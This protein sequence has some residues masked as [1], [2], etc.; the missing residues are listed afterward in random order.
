MI[1]WV[2]VY[3]EKFHTFPWKK[4]KYELNVFR[5]ICFI[6]T[7]IHSHAQQHCLLQSHLYCQRHSSRYIQTHFSRSPLSCANTFNLLNILYFQ[8]KCTH[9]DIVT[10]S[11]SHMQ[12]LVHLVLSVCLSLR[13]SFRFSH[14]LLRQVH[15]NRSW[16]KCSILFNVSSF[17]CVCVLALHVWVWMCV[18]LYVQSFSVVFQLWALAMC[19]K[20]YGPKSHF[21]ACRS[22]SHQIGRCIQLCV[23]LFLCLGVCDRQRMC[24]CCVPHF[25]ASYYYRY[26][27]FLFLFRKK[28]HT[29]D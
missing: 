23:H 26:V 20:W 9:C 6:Q 24:T 7:R 22:P 17:V 1:V 21:Y 19:G 8:Q 2:S 13:L 27:G 11:N 25:S 29:D 3:V 4:L 16:R 10:L 15:L 5:D 18:R 14:S 28:T 12:T